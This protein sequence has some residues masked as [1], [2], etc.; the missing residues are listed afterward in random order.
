[1]LKSCRECGEQVSTEADECPHCGTK[2]PTS[3]AQRRTT[4]AVI[5]GLLI[6]APFFYYFAKTVGILRSCGCLAIAGLGAL[7]ACVAIV[8][9]IA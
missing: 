2:N 1:V 9:V 3:E 7:G 4:A 5:I 8:F 6:A